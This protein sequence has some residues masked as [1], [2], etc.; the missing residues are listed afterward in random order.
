MRDLEKN[1]SFDVLRVVLTVFGAG[2]RGPGFHVDH[3]DLYSARARAGFCKEAAGETG[4]EEKVLKADLGKVFGAA[5]AFVEEAIRRAQEPV[6][7]TPTLDPDER[8]AALELLTDPKLIDRIGTDF[9]RAGMVG[10]T[11]NCLVGYLA[12]VSRSVGPAAR[13]R[14]A[15]DVGGRQERR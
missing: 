8:A 1:T 12:A 10:E 14:G 2:A 3:L 7:P 5:E 15:V 9:A 4:V 11:T 13:G 6:D